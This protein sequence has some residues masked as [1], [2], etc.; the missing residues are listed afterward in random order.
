MT[1]NPKKSKNLWIWL[2]AFI[3]GLI[4]FFKNN[5][6]AMKKASNYAANTG[7]PR[8]LHN[9]NPL[10]IRLT[11]IGWQGKVPNSENTDGSFEQFKTIAYGYR[12]AVKNLK[13]Y[14]GQGRSTL[15]E[16]IEKWAPTSDGNNPTGY[17]ARIIN[18]SS[19]INS[20][21][22]PILITNKGFMWELVREMAK[23]ENGDSYSS[24][25]KKSDFEA[26]WAL[27]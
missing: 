9:N 6:G 23:V 12:A 1:T 19:M 22:E 14:Y 25:I 3:L 27:I 24:Y 20:V 5:G 11:G 18:G 17:M 16:V 2:T 4:F 8:G 13:T 26:G 21:D 15:Q 10:N 7:L